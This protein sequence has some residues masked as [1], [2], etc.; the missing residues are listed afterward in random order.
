MSDELSQK[1]RLLALPL[2]ALSW[3]Y[4]G[5]MRLRAWF[6]DVGVL[7]SESSG[8]TIISI[9]NL[10]AGGTGKTPMTAFL[11]RRWGA[12]VRLGIL[13]RGYR[14]S[15]KGSHHVPVD[16]DDT[17]E[18]YGDEPAWFAREFRA[19]PRVPVQVA[20]DRVTGAR[21]L[22]IAE[23]TKVI[24]LD[25]GFQHLRLRRSFD[26]VLLDVSA[27]LWHWRSLP[28]G[29]LREPLSALRRA[30]AVILTKTDLATEERVQALVGR[31]R[32]HAKPN[33]PVL[34]F[35]QSLTWKKQTPY[36]PLLVAAG[37][38]RPDVFF[39]MVRAH[40]LQPVVKETIVFADHHRYTASDVEM[41]I[42][43]ARALDV[44]RVL[45][46]EKDAVKLESLWHGDVELAVARL[47][48]MPAGPEDEIALQ[49]I[50]A[51]LL[52]DQG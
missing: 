50:E 7:P 35:K 19:E 3:V 52:F 49:K 8:A 46:T 22:A 48:V 9:G 44:K 51:Q 11:A 18:K 6:Y 37:L 41:M 2:A 23:A 12:R 5:V 33:V 34:K 14:R 31:A 47:D 36:E 43:K 16:G 15:T 26:F 45:V 21:D 10:Q 42:E 17:A 13:S 4:E 40:A 32:R 24:L 29:R 28:L 25:D 20:E 27:P 30:D 1:Y 38:A 39:E